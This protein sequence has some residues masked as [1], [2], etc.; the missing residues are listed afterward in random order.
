MLS[1]APSSSLLARWQLICFIWP[2]FDTRGCAPGTSLAVKS[3]D[4]SDN[5]TAAAPSD[6]MYHQVTLTISS[7]AE[8]DPTAVI[9]LF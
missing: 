5:L 6:W 3:G 4:L 1:S 9:C 2:T 8:M 7:V